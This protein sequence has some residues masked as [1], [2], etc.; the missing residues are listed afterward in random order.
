[1]IVKETDSN[2]FHDIYDY[3]IVGAG[4]GGLV[5]A[6]YLAREKYKVLVLEQHYLVGGC[7]TT[8]SVGR[9]YYNAAACH[10][11]NMGEGQPF[12]ELLKDLECLDDLNFRFFDENDAVLFRNKKEDAFFISPSIPE[13]ADR[14]CNAYPAHSKDI[15]VFFSDFFSPRFMF[16][17]FGQSKALSFKEL[18]I[19]YKIPVPIIE[20]FDA[21]FLAYYTRTTDQ[22]HPY[23]AKLLL[24]NTIFSTR[25]MPKDNQLQSLSNLLANKFLRNGGHLKLSTDICKFKMTNEKNITEAIDVHNNVYRGQNFIANTS[26]ENIYEMI[27]SGADAGVLTQIRKAKKIV[28]SRSYLILYLSSQSQDIFNNKV[29]SVNC[30]NVIYSTKKP[31]SEESSFWENNFVYIT[32]PYFTKNKYSLDVFI[33]VNNDDQILDWKKGNKKLNH[34]NLLIE[35]IKNYI[36]MDQIDLAQLTAATPFTIRSFTKNSKGSVCGYSFLPENKPDE[37]FKNKSTAV[38]NLFFVGH[39]VG[40]AGVDQVALNAKKLFMLLKRDMK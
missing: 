10:L 23:A 18:L 19:S 28:Q 14:F 13:T 6:N 35:N 25:A 38:N 4:I 27:E 2:K 16:S 20:I 8:F 22:T 26:P 12:R 7:C 29:N 1:V 24:E 30:S 34:T 40:P 17:I 33:G 5:I 32:K 21:L 39:W 9:Q 36:D 3:V 31:E 15:K 11:A 37:Y